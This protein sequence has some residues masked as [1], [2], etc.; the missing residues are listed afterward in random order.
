[1]VRVNFM[2]LVVVLLII[3][4]QDVKG[5]RGRARSRSKSKVRNIEPFYQP[6]NQITLFETILF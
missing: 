4:S 3:C 6:L 5:R 1:M 2:I